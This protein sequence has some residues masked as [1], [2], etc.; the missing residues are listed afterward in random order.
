MTVHLPIAGLEKIQTKIN[1][2]IAVIEYTLYFTYCTPFV[3]RTFQS[4][5]AERCISDYY[6]LSG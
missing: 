4:Y 5:F 3:E 1:Q 6:Y 2:S